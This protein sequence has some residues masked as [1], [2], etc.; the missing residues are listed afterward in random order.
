MKLVPVLLCC[1]LPM[2]Q[3]K[4]KNINLLGNI[5]DMKC[6]GQSLVSYVNKEEVVQEES[7]LD[8]DCNDH[9]IVNVEK[10]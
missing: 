10:F 6:G 7:L 5:W 4:S 8:V 3:E 1:A 9:L 2:V